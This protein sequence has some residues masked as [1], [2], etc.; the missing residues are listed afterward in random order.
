MNPR[1]L[2][3]WTRVAFLVAAFVGGLAFDRTPA[4]PEVR[5]G[6]Y[7]VLEG[8]FHAH[9][10]FSDGSLTPM[11]LVQQA[12]RRGLDVIAVTEHNTA[13]PAKIAR[14]WSRLTG[15]PIVLVGEEVT[16][17]RFHLIAVGLSKTVPTQLAAEDVIADIHAQGG[18]AIAAHPVRS[19]W[20]ALVPA[21]AALDGA[22]VMH[23]IAYASS[24]PSWRWEDIVRYYEEASPRLLAIGSS[25]YHWGS[26]LGLCRTLVF[27][28]E[29]VTEASVL[30]ALRARRT[31]VIAPDGRRFGDPEMIAVLER[32]PYE[33]RTS[34][35]RYHG[36]GVLD[37]VLR[38]LGWLGLVGFVV[39]APRARRKPG[40]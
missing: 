26:V 32:E 35:Y 17:R 12:A 30:D 1:A 34:D 3:H 4:R 18:I 31:V 6:G 28:E 7:R 10:S 39:L 40:A 38:A 27:V 5:R 24:G 22:E 13:I 8:D 25:D 19:F 36:E 2:L 11:G 9:T 15:G 29:P 16:T 20:P 37:R 33:P 14:A 21:R 23:P